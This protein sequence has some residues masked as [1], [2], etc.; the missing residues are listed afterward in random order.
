MATV[1][2]N[3]VKKAFPLGGRKIGVLEDLTHTFLANKLT[4]IQGASGAG[5]TT[6]LQILG[7]IEPPEEGQVLLDGCDLYAMREGAR[8]RL[9]NRRIGFV[10]QSYHLL[11]E[12]TAL[13]NVLLPGAIGR[14]D[15][16]ARARELLTHVGLADRLEH[17][18]SELSGGEQQRVAIARALINEPD[19]LLADEPTG[20]LDSVTGHAVLELMLQVQSERGL[21]AIL[22]THDGAVAARGAER[23]Q[24][25]DG[26]IFHTKG[27]Q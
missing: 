16:R 11:P 26:R 22:V 9:R 20:N 5:K 1:Q 18:P 27:E 17:R 24:L 21:T 14:R 2:A 13:E 25:V 8:A 23:L 15:V 10:F 7:G 19:L 3:Q 6:L 4:T 12:L